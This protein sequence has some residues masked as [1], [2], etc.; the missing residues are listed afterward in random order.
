MKVIA[1]VRPELPAPE[2]LPG[3]DTAAFAGLDA[4]CQLIGWVRCRC[5]AMPVSFAA[6]SSAGFCPPVSTRQRLLGAGAGGA[7]RHVRGGDAPQGAT[8]DGV[9]LPGHFLCDASLPDSSHPCF[10]YLLLFFLGPGA[11]L[12][13]VSYSNPPRARARGQR[14]VP[15]SHGV[16]INV[17][18]N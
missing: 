7:A 16:M 3:P 13:R 11:F 1:G 5:A 14:A 10:S 15:P 9:R 2:V 4:Y 12:G 6:P 17:W 8:G 18:G